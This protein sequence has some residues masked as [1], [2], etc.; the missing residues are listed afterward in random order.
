[1]A[2]I[3]FSYKREDR[4]GI[5]PLV[6]L[7]ER[8]G[9]SVWWDPTIVAGE[10]F[11]E[12]ITREI[13]QA[14][15][16]IVAWSASSVNAVWVRD[17]ASSGRDRGVLVPLSLDG[18]QPPLGFR[19]FQTPDLS[20][21]SGSPEDPRIR[22]FIAGVGRVIRRAG[23]QPIAEARE[24]ATHADTAPAVEGQRRF[25]QPAET[26]HRDVS[27]S[28]V[29]PPKDK[30]ERALLPRRRVL[31]AGLA[32]GCV[33]AASAA[34]LL[35]ALP[36]YRGKRDPE[37]RS[38]TIDVVSVDEEGSLRSPQR[39]SVEVFDVPLAGDVTMEMA[40]IPVGGFQIGSPENEPQRREN[41]GPQQVVEIRSFALG[42]TAITQAE[43][44]AVVD[45]A[46]E[47]I[48]QTLSQYPSS[49][50]G[51]RLP[52][53]TV[54][55]NQSVEFCRRLSNLT[56]LPFRLPSEAEWEYACRAR[57]TTPFHFGPTLTPEVANYCG[58]GGAVCGTNNGQDISSTDYNGDP[59]PLGNYGDGPLGEFRQGTVDVRSFP[60]NR[61]G[62]F[63]MHGNV[64]EHCFDTG[65]AD[66]RHIPTD[67][68]PY[69][70]PQNRRV[71]RG[72]SWSHNPAIC[73]SAYRD[74]MLADSTG[75]QGRVGFRVACDL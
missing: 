2:D 49:F 11:D 43:W 52:V 12:V 28:T 57:T 44:A 9:F 24:P 10:R 16:V 26:P 70:G 67:G 32:L 33:G 74:S 25:E 64:W 59:Y 46:P 71:L 38:E 21:W 54:S 15:C 65:I 56:G 63:E 29:Q 23:T 62:L 45:A 31:K 4:T 14:S 8:E 58:T 47:R 55:W 41:E 6:R 3:F 17:E 53:E 30:R 1:M 66:Y 51:D 18:V 48:E 13:E 5:E 7:L 36:A 20:G 22:Q 35:F 42:R 40:V 68:S 50:R 72:G 73:R 60:P 39:Q 75:W 37:I 69:V 27:A 19:Q 61:F 34:G